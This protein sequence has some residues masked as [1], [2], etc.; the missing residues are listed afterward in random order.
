MILEGGLNFDAQTVSGS[1]SDCIANTGFGSD[2][3]AKLGSGSDCIAKTG[4]GSDWIANS[5]PD[6]IVLLNGSGSGYD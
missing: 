2:C 1:L 6:P 5:D 3:I 4:S